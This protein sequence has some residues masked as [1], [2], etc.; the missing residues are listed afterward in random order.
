MVK[1]YIMKTSP[2]KM[3]HDCFIFAVLVFVHFLEDVGRERE[4]ERDAKKMSTG[5]HL[6]NRVRRS[7]EYW[8]LI[9]PSIGIVK[10][11]V[12]HV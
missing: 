1:C 8:P 9:D 12:P 4:M 5:E 3:Y 11:D 2:S 6:K 10:Q 7:V